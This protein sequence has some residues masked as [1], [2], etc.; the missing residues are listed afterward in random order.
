MAY[1]AKTQRTNASVRDFIEAIENQ[2]QK[3]EA[4]LLLEL[5]QDISNYSAEMW[6]SSIIGF[7]SYHYR[8]ASGQEGDWMRGGFS[9]RKGKHSLY[10]MD[11]FEQHGDLLKQ[12]GKCKTGKSCLY[13]NKLE[14][15]NLDTLKELI[16]ASF[17][18]MRKLYP[19]D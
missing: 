4:Y 9:P 15:I 6:G 3:E 13:I 7:G 5:Y 2:K 1:Q 14:D 10:L 19:E 8:Y 17:D 18:H 12:L 16:Q 11:G